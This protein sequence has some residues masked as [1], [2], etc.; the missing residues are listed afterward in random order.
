MS[1]KSRLRFSSRFK[2]QLEYLKILTIQSLLA[3]SS[4]TLSL[5]FLILCFQSRK[6][7]YIHK[8]P[9]VCLFRSSFIN[10]NPST[11]RNHHPSSF[12]L[13]PSSFFIHSTSFFIHPSFIS[14]LLSF[15]AC[16]LFLTMNENMN[17]ENMM[18]LLI[19][20]IKNN[21]D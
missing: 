3:A 8:C 19:L 11:V 17:E 7:L 13:H 6:Q 12:N 21:Q 9:F 16:F 18:F 14:W 20:L 1:G 2:M 15:S 4:V 5:W 10:Q